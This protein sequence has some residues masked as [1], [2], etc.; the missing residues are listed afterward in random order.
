MDLLVRME[1]SDNGETGGRERLSDRGETE[2]GDRL[3]NKGENRPSERGEKEMGMKREE[4]LDRA[5]TFKHIT[6]SA[7]G[8]SSQPPVRAESMGLQTHFLSP[9][10]HLSWWSWWLWPWMCEGKI[11][12]NP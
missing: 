9:R 12:G 11:W 3:S 10:R 5:D 1:V 6:L 7:W 8:R 4:E 2:G